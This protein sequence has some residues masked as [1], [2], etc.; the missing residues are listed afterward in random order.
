MV[1]KLW[2]FIHWM[3]A[4]EEHSQHAEGGWRLKLESWEERMQT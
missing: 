3:G 1:P 4:V 2:V